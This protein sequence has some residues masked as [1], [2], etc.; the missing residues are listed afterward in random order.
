M[1]AHF[2]LHQFGSLVRDVFDATPYHVGSS[3]TGKV[4]RDVDVRVMLDKAGWDRFIGEGKD[5]GGPMP[6]GSRRAV[7]EMAFDA[8]GK[9]ITGLP[10]DFQVQQVDEANAKYDGPR[11]ALGYQLH[12]HCSAELGCETPMSADRE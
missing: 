8:L 12:H 4:W 3:L 2:Y 5:E 11:S 7:L 6:N 9:H 10:I 1:P